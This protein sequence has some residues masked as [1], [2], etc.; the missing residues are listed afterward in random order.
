MVPPSPPR[1]SVPDTARVLGTVLAPAV[2]QGPILRRPK[3]LGLLDRL[4]ADRRAADLVRH[5]RASYSGGPLL[6]AVPGRPVLLLLTASQV[7]EVLE[8][9]PEPFTPASS[10][11]AAALGHFQ[12][13]GVLISRGPV[14]QDRRRF[15]EAVLDVDRPV[16]HLGEHV[17]R[18]AR[19]EVGA[20]VSTSRFAG[21]FGWDDWHA[22]WWRVVRRVVLGDDARGDTEVTELLDT[23]RGDANWAFLRP[24]RGGL[25]ER[26]DERL[27]IHLDRRQPGSLASVLPEV[28]A[29]E[30]TDPQGQ[31]PHWLFAYD[32][33]AIVSIRALAVLATYE[34]AR[35]RVHEEARSSAED[36]TPLLPFLRACVLESV[37][38]WPT[39]LAILRETTADTTVA[40]CAVP[41]GAT[42]VIHSSSFHRDSDTL[43]YADRFEPEVWLDGRARDEWSLVPFSGGP[44]RCPGKDLVL[45][46]T[47]AVLAAL[48]ERHDVGLAAGR[49]P[50]AGRPLPHTL[51]HTRLRFELWRRLTPRSARRTLDA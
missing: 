11:K 25:R 20:L 12:P 27:R 16:H 33:A 30:D 48:L 4:D 51:D 50:A 43:P 21:G 14:R 44:A 40:G 37:R 47:S 45:M 17:V 32:A 13:H 46:T 1:A 18:V 34:R 23:L 42:V 6:L 2:G 28:P 15:N 29:G 5:L 31:V 7:R 3:V 9:A 8:G 35:E 10:E 24:R 26:F 41:R 22:M 39:T 49:L 19:D 38:L 36:P